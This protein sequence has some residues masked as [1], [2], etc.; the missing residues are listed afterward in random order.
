MPV[1]RVVGESGVQSRLEAASRK[2]LTPL[3]GREQE[4]GL[5]LERW[6]QVKDGMG[7]VVI[8]SGE[9]G[10]GKSRLLQVVKEAI[11]STAH[12]R[13]ECRSSPYYQNTTL[14]PITDLL[15][16]T[17]QWQPDASST[18][19]LET[20][21]HL[22]SQYRL[23]LTETV[24][25]FATLLSMPLPEERYAPLPWTPQRQRQKTLESLVAMLVELA[26]RQPVL[27]ILEDLHWTDPT[28]LELLGLLMDQTPTAALLVL[29]TC[30]PAFASPWGL[31]TYVTPLALQR[32]NR[33]QIEA[34]VQRVTGEKILPAE[35]GV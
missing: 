19:R 15:Q 35:V 9:A 17:L 13:W 25:L 29:L 31:R 7:Q 20:L 32:F 6:A 16:R 10:I 8:L 28:T 4:V 27:F 30:R 34:M 11:A 2:G 3:V 5:L 18:Q 14:Y 33:S 22:L 12:T 1:Y 21:E 24:P 23:S 26:E